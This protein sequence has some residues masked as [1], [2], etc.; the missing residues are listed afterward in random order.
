MEIPYMPWFSD[1]AGSPDGSRIAPPAMAPS[2][3]FNGVETPNF[4]I[5]RLTS[6]ACNYP[7]QRFAVALTD[8]DA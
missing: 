7:R 3:L 5:S 2:G 6:P 1:R 8:A 4:L